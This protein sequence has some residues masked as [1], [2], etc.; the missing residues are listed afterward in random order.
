MTTGNTDIDTLAS[1]SSN[2]T[3]ASGLEVEVQALRM[4]QTMGLLKIVTRGAGPILSELQFSDDMDAGAFAGTLIGAVILAV[5]EAE[6]ETVDFIKSMVKPA[7]LISDPRSKPER[8]VNSDLLTRLSV[9]LENPDLDDF[10]SIIEVVINSEAPHL[11]ALG[12]RLT[13]LIAAQRKLTD[14]TPKDDSK[15]SSSSKK[16]SA[17]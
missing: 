17:A 6:D 1:E 3:L 4:R 14:R 16:S 10:V 12:K 11:V 9:E 13:G 2:I 7:G 15:P 8:E 5:P